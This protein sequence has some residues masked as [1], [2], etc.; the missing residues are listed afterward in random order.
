VYERLTVP[1]ETSRE[2]QAALVQAKRTRWVRLLLPPVGLVVLI[3]GADA[4]WTGRARALAR[5]NAAEAWA[6]YDSCVVGAPLRSGEAA[7]RRLRRIEMNLPESRRS[8]SSEMWP[9]RCAYHLDDMH[10][11][12]VRGRL[13]DKDESL[14]HLDEVARIA[15]VDLAPES[16]PDLADRL[17]SAAADSTLRPP[18]ARPTEVDPPAPVPA[19]PLT[20]EGLPPL[21]VAIRAPPE[22]ADHLPADGLRILFSEPSGESSLCSFRPGEHGE[23]FRTAH[24]ADNVVPTSTDDATPGFVRSVQGRFDRFELIRP[25]SGADPQILSLPAGTQAIAL[26]SDQLVWISSDHHLLARTIPQEAAEPGAPSDLGEI[27]GSSPELA[28]CRTDTSLVIRARSYDDGAGLNRVWA[29]VAIR[30][31]EV[32]ERAP[33]E[34]AIQVDAT[35]TC[36][37]KEGTF[38]SFD[39]GMIR[40]ARCTA[41]GCAV[42]ASEPFS[43]PWDSGRPN[44]VADVDGKTIVVGIGM[45]AGPVIAGSVTTV[46]MRLAEVSEIAHAPDV[47]LLGD[48]AHEGVDATDA[49]VYVRRGAALVL[50]TTKDR[51]PYRAIAV[52][53]TGTFEPLRVEKL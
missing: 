39:R 48:V 41:A 17:W 15:R 5:K 35:F 18:E 47:V 24:C 12:L 38:T 43:L 20:A 11:A 34:V 23:P 3:L 26:F 19:E 1:V 32:W 33:K 8:A 6:E 45:T 50:V 21:P 10:A 13:L 7:T 29:T 46:R 14:S 40:Q 49:H 30:T 2:V 22:E 37:G 42:A 36:R 31:G 16:A 52:A 51:E 9:T 25:L 53:P 4:I 27:L 28:A 44:R